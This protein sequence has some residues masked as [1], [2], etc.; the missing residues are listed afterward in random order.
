MWNKCEVTFSLFVTD[1]DSY[2]DSVSIKDALN[3]P[4]YLPDG[5]VAHRVEPSG[6]GYDAVFRI[7]GI[8]VTFDAGRHVQRSLERLGLR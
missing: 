4:G 1:R 2:H 7:D 6:R 5:W 8:N 3:A